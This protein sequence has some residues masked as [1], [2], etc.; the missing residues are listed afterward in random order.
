MSLLPSAR[1]RLTH[2]S[3]QSFQGSQ[4]G[5]IERAFISVKGIIDVVE[6]HFHQ[7][8]IIDE[9]RRDHFT[10]EVRMG[11]GAFNSNFVSHHLTS[12]LFQSFLH[13]LITI[14]PLTHYLLKSRLEI[15]ASL[16]P[17]HTKT[18]PPNPCRRRNAAEG[19]E[20]RGR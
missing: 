13:A 5:D 14:T 6:A 19:W 16:I 15:L 8:D 18:T 10:T 1:G 20:T 2:I 12:H 3:S 4:A 7:P 17:D 11:E 9:R